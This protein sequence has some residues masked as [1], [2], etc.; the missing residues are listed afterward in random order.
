MRA[1]QRGRWLIAVPFLLAAC[2][3]EA[4]VSS[5]ASMPATSALTST[6]VS[7][8]TNTTSSPA[9]VVATS[10]TVVQ[11]D[12]PSLETTT[13]VSAVDGLNP[14]AP[15]AA[16][17]ARHLD[18]ARLAGAL[19]TAG[20]LSWLPP[21]ATVEDDSDLTSRLVEYDCAGTGTDVPS[22]EPSATNRRYLSGQESVASITFYDVETVDDARTFMSGM[23]AHVDCPSPPSTVVTFEA[24]NL[25]TPAPCDDAVVIRTHQ[26]VSE[27]IDA[28]CQVANLIAW[29]RLYPSGVIAA[30]TDAA[31]SAPIPPTDDQA[32]QTM[33]VTAAA[34]RA[35]WDTAS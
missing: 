25:N 1:T 3:S 31:A 34:L 7:P 24:V 6:G 27:T 2:G 13:P 30:E 26:P 29:I 10:S 28:W 20:D 33:I 16:L 21:D 9:T 35:A 22:R 23:N 32:S 11:T 18:H 17:D 14:T 15:N 19:P 5:P 12:P 4:T 8:P